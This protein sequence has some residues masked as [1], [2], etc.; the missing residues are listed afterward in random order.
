MPTTVRKDARKAILAQAKTALPQAVWTSDPD[1]D[2]II[3][4]HKGRVI[5]AQL[6]SE[7][8]TYEESIPMEGVHQGELWRWSI[9]FLIPASLEDSAEDLADDIFDA[10]DCALTPVEG[11]SPHV[12]LGNLE[13][14]EE[15]AD[16]RT[17]NGHRLFH[18]TYFARR[19][20]G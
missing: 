9:L 20:R 1:P 7:P 15:A 16:G 4:E 3:R 17:E 13:L 6:Q 18:A 14:E 5:L 12:E 10:L 19:W 8:R 2:R 11:W